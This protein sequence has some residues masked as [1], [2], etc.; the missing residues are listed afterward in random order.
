MAVTR[1][2]L[3]GMRD[4][5]YTY[6]YNP[7]MQLTIASHCVVLSGADALHQALRLKRS[8]KIHRLLAGPNLFTLPTEMA[9]ILASPEVDLCLVPSQWV[10]DLYLTC[11]PSLA[12]RIAV[13]AA[14]VNVEEWTVPTRIKQQKG[15]VILLYVKSG[16]SEEDLEPLCD[17]LLANGANIIRINYGSYDARQYKQCLAE[18]DL[19]VFIS[20]SE[21]QGIALQE[22]WSCNKP[23]WIYDPGYWEAPDRSRY[24]ASSAPYLTDQCGHTFRDLRELETLCKRWRNGNFQYAARNWVCQNM[25]DAVCAEKLMKLLFA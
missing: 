22:A 24:F 23:T 15:L 13:W 7:V 11:M 6:N 21:S 8:G 17:L 20:A 10:K 19:C 18:A 3:D 5:S 4:T 2:L 12:G 9:G 1:S 25:T 14:G 16:M